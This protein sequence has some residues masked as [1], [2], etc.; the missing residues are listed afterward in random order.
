M[1]FKHYRLTEL[2]DACL[3]E[4]YVDVGF[5]CELFLEFLTDVHACE[6]YLD[7][8]HYFFYLFALQFQQRKHRFLFVVALGLLF[9]AFVYNVQQS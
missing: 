2:S 1:E 5:V 7:C 8:L 9:L 4:V 6:V 3:E